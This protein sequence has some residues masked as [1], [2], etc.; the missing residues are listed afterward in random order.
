MYNPYES[1]WE[2]SR[3]CKKVNLKSVDS[4]RQKIK[5]KNKNYKFYRIDKEK[6]VELFHNGGWHFNNIMTPEEISLKLKT[7]AHSEYSEDK[8]SS[9]KIIKRK[10]ENKEDLFERGHKYKFVNLDKKFPKFIL[11]NRKK[12]EKFIV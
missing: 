10:I 3:V 7:F 1:P 6:S 12:F 11:E 4:M 9:I 5:S 2:G 8:Y